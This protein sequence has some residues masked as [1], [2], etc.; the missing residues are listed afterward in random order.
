[1]DLLVAVN[2]YYNG[3]VN[4]EDQQAVQKKI[5][6]WHM[7]LKGYEFESIMESLAAYVVTNDF[8]PKISQLVRNVSHTDPNYKIP[9]IDET[10]EMLDRY[11]AEIAE[12]RKKSLSPAEIEELFRKSVPPEVFESYMRNKRGTGE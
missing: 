7:V 2:E 6:A 3:F 1:M 8:P 5:N 12:N 10:K 11:D 9:G 4:F